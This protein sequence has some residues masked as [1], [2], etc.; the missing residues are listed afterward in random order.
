MGRGFLAESLHDAAFGEFRRQMEYKAS[1]TGRTLVK[2]DR[3]FPSSK[4]C[5]DC[6]HIHEGLKLG[7]RAWTCA[8]CGTRHQRDPNS[9][10]NI[11][12]ETLRVVAGSA[13]RQEL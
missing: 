2:V 4:R 11:H 3:Y 8:Q 9:A 10:I 7:D 12:A 5:S 13:V 6:G 1:W